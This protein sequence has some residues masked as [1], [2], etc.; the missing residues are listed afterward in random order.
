MLP[1]KVAKSAQTTADRRPLQW[2]DAHL[3]PYIGSITA[4]SDNNELDIRMLMSLNRNFRDGARAILHNKAWAKWR[5]DT[6][7][8]LEI[9]V[10]NMI[11][12]GNMEIVTVLVGY[13]DRPN[14][15]AEILS[16]IWESVGMEESVYNK[17][18]TV[19]LETYN[20]KFTD[21]ICR[22]L[23]LAEQH[24]P[25]QIQ[26]YM[27]VCLM[28]KYILENHISFFF[29]D[30][31]T[32]ADVDE[33]NSTVIR[34]IF[35][36]LDTSFHIL[37]KIYQVQ[38]ARAQD[39]SRSVNME[40]DATTAD[41]VQIES[42]VQKVCA[43]LIHHALKK[44]MLFNMSTPVN[45]I[46]VTRKLCRRHMPQ[47]L[48]FSRLTRYSETIIKKHERTMRSILYVYQIVFRKHK[49][50]TETHEYLDSFLKEAE[51]IILEHLYQEKHSYTDIRNYKDNLDYH[52][53]NVLTLCEMHAFRK[54][55]DIAQEK[56]A[57]RLVPVLTMYFHV[58]PIYRRSHETIIQFLC[59]LNTAASTTPPDIQHSILMGL[60]KKVD[61]KDVIDVLMEGKNARKVSSLN[62][63][64]G[65]DIDHLLQTL[66]T[67]SLEIQT[68]QNS[69]DLSRLMQTRIFDFFVMKLHT[70]LNNPRRTKEEL[71]LDFKI[72][73]RLVGIRRFPR[74][75]GFIFAGVKR[76]TGELR[77]VSEETL[78]MEVP[79]SEKTT[80]ISDALKS[81][82]RATLT[83]PNSTVVEFWVHRVTISKVLKV[84]RQLSENTDFDE[85]LWWT[86][87]NNTRST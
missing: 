62:W 79:D 3:E 58:F 77:L 78:R 14:I 71:A 36:I 20:L 41:V 40:L 63:S 54:E 17:F 23:I 1:R 76:T 81:E 48:A 8:C 59:T 22:V 19:A 83:P 13:T 30:D 28:L 10:P 65:D 45:N 51:E 34:T 80:D 18:T 29:L 15:Q 35:T 60:V 70:W 5:A 67:N 73:A 26:S 84:I 49:N 12:E 24:S 82:I 2:D 85:E 56:M 61:G 66:V 75:R 44:L 46:I 50:P 52:D 32:T 68:E 6:K 33:D 11:A 55:L 7:Q 69:I 42:D 21:L 16:M 72:I 53:P 27:N 57:R 37:E 9:T 4:P 74:G 39:G 47:M 38:H 64:P 31:L 86:I 25:R 43:E 87:F